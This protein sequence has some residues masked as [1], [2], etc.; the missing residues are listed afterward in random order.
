[1]NY[2]L[3]KMFYSWGKLTPAIGWYRENN[4]IDDKQYQTITGTAYQAPATDAEK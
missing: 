2:T 3:I 1:M 4:F